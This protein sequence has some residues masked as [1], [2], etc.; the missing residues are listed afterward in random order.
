MNSS[1]PVSAAFETRHPIIN[2]NPPTSNIA[3]ITEAIEAAGGAMLLY[4]D[5]KPCAAIVRVNMRDWQVF[6]NVQ[7]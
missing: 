2:P 5:G 7:I 1:D 4:K 6:L 3:A